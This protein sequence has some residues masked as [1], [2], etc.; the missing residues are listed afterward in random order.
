[1][2]EYIEKKKKR[3]AQKK[4]A[5]TAAP[6]ADEESGDKMETTKAIEASDSD[7]TPKKIKTD[8]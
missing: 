6:T 1:M 3:M 4:Q 8:N 5:K 7:N 2:P